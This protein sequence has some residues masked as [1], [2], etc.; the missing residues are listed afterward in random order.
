MA[1][2]IPQQTAVRAAQALQT[3]AVATAKV[4][5]QW[6]SK[7]I[8]ILTDLVKSGSAHLMTA[9]KGF[10]AFS[11]KAGNVALDYLKSSASQMASFCSR[12]SRE[13]TLL[14]V[15]AVSALLVS[16]AASRFIASTA[17]TEQAIV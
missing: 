6:G 4:A 5:G 12:N 14:G 9:L 7:A 3:H 8:T 13:I 10:I 17:S 15:G 16:Y 1:S 11:G 2:G